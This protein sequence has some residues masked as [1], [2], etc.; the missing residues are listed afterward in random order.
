MSPHC[1][2]LWQIKWPA[3]FVGIC[4]RCCWISRRRSLRFSYCSCLIMKTVSN[5][6]RLKNGRRNNPK[7]LI[8]RCSKEDLKILM[9]ISNTFFGT[10]AI[11]IAKSHVFYMILFFVLF[12]ICFSILFSFLSWRMDSETQF[13]L[14]QSVTMDLALLHVKT[15]ANTNQQ[16]KTK[17][18]FWQT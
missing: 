7:W 9:T 12:V 6:S 3:F 17:S 4:R 18:P 11:P 5:N 13:I 2:V 1:S 10:Y 16:I 14:H 15:T 8:K